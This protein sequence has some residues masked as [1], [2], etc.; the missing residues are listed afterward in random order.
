MQK[1]QTENL[2]QLTLRRFRRSNGDQED[3]ENHI[4]DEDE[5]VAQQIDSTRILDYHDIERVKQVQTIE[6]FLDSYHHFH[7]YYGADLIP[8]KQFEAKQKRALDRRHKRLANKITRKIINE[9]GLNTCSWSE[10]CCG[11]FRF[12]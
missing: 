2:K 5:E 7:L 8:M 10:W 12:L 9:N 11:F 1:Y 3:D 4:D 6:E